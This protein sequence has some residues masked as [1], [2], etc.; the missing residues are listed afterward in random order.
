MPLASPGRVRQQTEPGEIDGHSLYLVARR[1]GAG[2][3]QYR[4]GDPGLGTPVGRHQQQ[5]RRAADLTA[6]VMDDVDR[7]LLP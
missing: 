3:G 6:A 7:L 1:A 2:V 5:E 4:D